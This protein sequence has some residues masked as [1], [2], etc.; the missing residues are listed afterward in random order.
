M[1]YSVIKNGKELLTANIPNGLTEKEMK[2]GIKNT[3]KSVFKNNVAPTDL[4]HEVQ[5]NHDRILVMSR[6]GKLLFTLEKKKG[7]LSKLWNT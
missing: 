6:R 4:K 2:A 5:K 7:W 1:K 3:W